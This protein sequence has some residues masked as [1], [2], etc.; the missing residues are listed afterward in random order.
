MSNYYSPINCSILQTS[1]I[2]NITT[3]QLSS[4][5]YLQVADMWTKLPFS[6]TQTN[7]YQQY[8]H[9]HN[10]LWRTASPQ[11]RLSGGCLL[12]THSHKPCTAN[13]NLTNTVVAFTHTLSGIPAYCFC[14]SEYHNVYSRQVLSWSLPIGLHMGKNNLQ[15]SHFF[16][17]GPGHSEFFT[18]KK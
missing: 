7:S 13:I 8:T 16:Q 6:H 15:H 12:Y 11:P 10:L 3:D 1:V 18:L 14:Y 17:F 4:I 5:I 9:P 2:L